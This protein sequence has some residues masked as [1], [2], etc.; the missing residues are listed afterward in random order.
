MAVKAKNPVLSLQ[1]FA[2]QRT[3]AQQDRQQTPLAILRRVRLGHGVSS[4]TAQRLARTAFRANKLSI[5]IGIPPGTPRGEDEPEHSPCFYYE[6]HDV[7]KLK[8][9]GTNTLEASA[10]LCFGDGGLHIENEHDAAQALRIL[11]DG[12]REPELILFF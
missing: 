6:G 3:K 4:S 9:L 12:Y 10:T 1:E 2:L 11:E 7:M 8:E 5:Q